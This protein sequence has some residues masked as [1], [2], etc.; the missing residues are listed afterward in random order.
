MQPALPPRR[1]P[2]EKFHKRGHSFGS[3]LPS[4]SK[5]DELTLFTEMQK[6]DKDNFLLEPLED[7]D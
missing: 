7:F 5:D 6:H 3:I 1:S 4:K 2:K